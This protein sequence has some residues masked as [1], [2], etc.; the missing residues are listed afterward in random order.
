MNERNLILWALFL[1]FAIFFSFYICSGRN[2]CNMRE[3]EGKNWFEQRRLVS[4]MRWSLRD[5]EEHWTKKKKTFK[6]QTTKF[7]LLVKWKSARGRSK[8]KRNER[9]RDELLF[10]AKWKSFVVMNFICAMRDFRFGIFTVENVYFTLFHS[11]TSRIVF[12]TLTFCVVFL[13]PLNKTIIK[14]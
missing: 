2:K 6:S 1:S 9:T 7:C 13:H 10:M 3:D 4:D 5:E 8:K 14:A 12:S 11:L